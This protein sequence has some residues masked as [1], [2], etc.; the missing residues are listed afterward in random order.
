LNPVL[1]E[2]VTAFQ[3]RVAPFPACEVQLEVLAPLLSNALALFTLLGLPHVPIRG[4]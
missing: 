4:A 1:L 3:I 2:K